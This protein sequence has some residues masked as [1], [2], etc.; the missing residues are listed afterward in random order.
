MKLKVL[1]LNRRWPSDNDLSA[2]VTESFGRH[3]EREVQTARTKFSDYH[4]QFKK[5]IMKLTKEFLNR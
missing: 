2:I 1:F 4:Y 3:I 5:E